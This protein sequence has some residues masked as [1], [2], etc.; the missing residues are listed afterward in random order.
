MRGRLSFRMRIALKHPWLSG[1]ASGAYLVLKDAC[2]RIVEDAGFKH[3]TEGLVTCLKM[4]HDFLCLLDNPNH[5][6]VSTRHLVFN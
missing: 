4:A 1:D 5:T 6:G 2:S 3:D